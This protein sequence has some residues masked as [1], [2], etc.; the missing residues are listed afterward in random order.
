MNSSTASTVFVFVSARCCFSFASLAL[1]ASARKVFAMR[2]IDS[3]VA[4]GA[5]DA[6]LP[7]RAGGNHRHERRHDRR[8]ACGDRVATRELAEAVGRA[9]R[10]GLDGLAAQM[11]LEIRRELN[12]VA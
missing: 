5:G 2:L 7:Q 3:A 8:D 10:A 9:R 12:G 4:L 6:R 11:A 1:P